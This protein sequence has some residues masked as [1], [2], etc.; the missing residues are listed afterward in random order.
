MYTIYLFPLPMRNKT[1]SK[2]SK[3]LKRL[4]MSF[5]LGINVLLDN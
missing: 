5:L 1:F 4:D 2:S 3:K